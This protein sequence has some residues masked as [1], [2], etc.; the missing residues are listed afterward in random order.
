MLNRTGCAWHQS[1]AATD[2]EN[3]IER[4]TAADSHKKTQIGHKLNRRHNAMRNFAVY[5]NLS[6]ATALTA[7]IAAFSGILDSTP[8]GGAQGCCAPAASGCS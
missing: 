3:R 7:V 5:G 8:V 6:D 2:L 4:L 1:Q